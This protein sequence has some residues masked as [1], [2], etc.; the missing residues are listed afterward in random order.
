RDALGR[1]D[2]L[3]WVAG[4]HLGALPVY[5]ELAGRA[6]SPAEAPLVVQF[7]AHLDVH[8]FADCS[9]ELP[10]GNFLLRCA[11]PLPRLVNVG[12]RELLL[13]ED[14]VSRFYRAAFPASG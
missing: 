11:G 9:P 14:Y 10:P 1:G 8:H 12:H 2:F 4:N 7:D 6:R 5:D 13:P 3:I